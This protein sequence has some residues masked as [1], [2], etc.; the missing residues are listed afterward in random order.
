MD[1]ERTVE[2]HQTGFD[3]EN[4]PWGGSSLGSSCYVSYMWS[5][6]SFLVVLSLACG[7][8]TLLACHES[9]CHFSSD[10]FGGKAGFFR[11]EA[12]SLPPP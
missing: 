2:S 11:G 10:F 8:V 5:I 9:A 1:I 3:L 6:A 12:S 4:F 7:A